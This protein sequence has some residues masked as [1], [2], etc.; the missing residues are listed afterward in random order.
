[1]NRPRTPEARR[2][3]YVFERSRRRDALL[4][5]IVSL[6]ANMR[7]TLRQSTRKDKRYQ[8]TFETQ[9][10]TR[11]I[12]FGSSCH[13]N[14]TMHG[15]PRRRARYI[16]RHE[17]RERWDDPTTA[18]FWSRWLSWEEP[19]MNDAIEALKRN[20]RIELHLRIDD[21]NP[22]QNKNENII[23]C[24]RVQKRQDMSRTRK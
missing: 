3:S 24:R 6:A 10:G 12:H 4:R 9:D 8:V 1:M 19:T 7:A 13:E 21:R 22:E 5:F 15:D 18:G 17:A 11:T 14:Y 23:V 16:S 2:A 20:K